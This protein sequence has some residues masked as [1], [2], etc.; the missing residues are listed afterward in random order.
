MCEY[1]TRQDKGF[2]KGTYVVRSSGSFMSVFASSCVTISVDRFKKNPDADADRD[3]ARR[4]NRDGSRDGPT[5]GRRSSRTSTDPA[6]E[7]LGNRDTHALRSDNRDKTDHRP[8]S[9]RSSSNRWPRSRIENTFRRE[10]PGPPHRNQE[11][12]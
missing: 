8:N 6:G 10:P 11:L 3:T 12:Y 9:K 1:F 5:A 4:T 7:S 2:G